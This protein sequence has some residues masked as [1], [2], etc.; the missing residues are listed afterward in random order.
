MDA[1]LSWLKQPFQ[2]D[3]DAFHWFLF[4][5]LIIV[6]LYLWHMVERDFGLTE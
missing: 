5:G 1:L 6:S 4:V 2:T 3:Q